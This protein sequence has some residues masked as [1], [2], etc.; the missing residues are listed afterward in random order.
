MRRYRESD[1]APLPPKGARP[2]IIGVTGGVGTGKSTVARMFGLRLKGPV[3][4]ADRIA[5][6]LMRPSSA[7]WRKIRSRFG[8]EGVVSKGQ[9]DRRRLGEIAFGNPKKLETLCR[10]I[11]PAVRRW[12]QAELKRIRRRQPQAR[13]I[14]DIPLL[15]EAGSQGRFRHPYPLDFLVVVSAPLRVVARR[16][17]KRSGWGLEEI[18]RRQGFQSPLGR[19]EQLADFVVNNGGTLG[20]TRRQVSRIC[21]NALHKTV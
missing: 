9:I 18:Q 10:I 6:Q 1:L 21:L 8:K 13:V 4:D 19:K 7:V 16:L 5:H 12:I 3:L 15:I 11:H 14:L 17:K 20:S 2:L